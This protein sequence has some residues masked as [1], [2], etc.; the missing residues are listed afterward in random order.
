MPVGLTWRVA[1]QSVLALA[2]AALWAVAMFGRTSVGGITLPSGLALLGAWCVVLAW[3]AWCRRR[4]S[5]GIGL[6]PAAA[7]SVAVLTVLYLSD[8]AH[9]HWVFAAGPKALA[10]AVGVLLV[11]GAGTLRA[12]LPLALAASGVLHALSFTQVATDDLIRYWG[13]ADGLVA[14]A[15]YSVTAG[16][17]GSAD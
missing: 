14:G 9:H 7:F 10:L 8:T 5:D 13:I 3:L 17:P 6:I 15:G 16:V 11:W 2:P 4:K 1:A 12:P